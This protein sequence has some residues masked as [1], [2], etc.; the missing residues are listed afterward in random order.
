MKIFTVDIFYI[1]M[2]CLLAF[3]ISKPYIY[4][5]QQD[6]YRL[7]EIF[8][9]K[10]IRQCYLFD[11]LAIFVTLIFWMVCY[12]LKAKEIWYSLLMLFFLICE[13]VLYIVEELPS[14]KKP[15]VYTKRVVRAMVFLL[16]MS[17]LIVASTVAIFNANSLLAPFKHL[18]YLTYILLFPLFFII[19]VGFINVFERLN[20]IKYEKR[21]SKTMSCCP[22]LIKIAI[23]GSYAKTSVKRYLSTILSQ[24]YKVFAT[25]NS[26]NTPMGIA[27][28]VKMMGDDTE[29]FI[30]EFGARRVN[31]ISRLM[32][33]V[34][35]TH[36][37]LT[38]INSQHLQTFKTQANIIKEK[39]KILD[40]SDCVVVNYS[41]SNIVEG[42]VSHLKHNPDIIYSS[43][44][45]GEIFASNIQC[46][47]LGCTFDIAY[48][49]ESYPV[50][51]RVIGKHN[52]DNIMLAVAMALYLGMSIEQVVYGTSLIQ[53]IE[54]RLQL[55]E[56]NGI[57]IIDD[58]F[59][60][61][62]DSCRVALDTLSMFEGRKVVM[63]PGLIELGKIE[64]D[65]N[66]LLGQEIANVAD[67][68]ILIGKRNH[69]A[70]KQG[71]DVCNKDIQVF[72]FDTLK[73]AEDNF[74]DILCV[75]DNLL[76]LNDLPDIYE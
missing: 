73:D 18:V 62:P 66:R 9:T 57:N 8:H 39:C 27:K 33:I 45:G 35:P 70:L 68:I 56:G 32:K 37:I 61:N 50:Y 16:L 13:L 4:A 7:M 26:Y 52:I 22:H 6:N 49:G 40:V 41:L 12:F 55:I 44:E 11:L 63:T 24:K 10:R 25:P 47:K 64:D 69:L 48:K 31:D 71:I 42:H 75:N 60:A 58:S 2:V 23:T 54:H 29:V 74:K 15:L 38:S 1:L 28:S 43:S 53:P 76:I 21:A 34:K 46:S 51:T 72:S 17:T 67:V 3:F 36:A 14:R 20:N 5:I 19:F 30:A 65:E 59:N